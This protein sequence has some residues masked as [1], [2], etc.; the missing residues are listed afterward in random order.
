[1]RKDERKNHRNRRRGR[2]IDFKLV[3]TDGQKHTDRDTEG[4]RYI[5]R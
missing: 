1:M 3:E 2:D 5:D 4:D